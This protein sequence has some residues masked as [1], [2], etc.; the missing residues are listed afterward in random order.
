[1]EIIKFK[2]KSF[3]K[4][5][6]PYDNKNG[7]VKYVCYANVEDLPVE[8]E[9]W[10]TSNPRE[11]N[12]K[13]D[14]AKSIKA[15]LESQ[16]KNFHELNRGI[17]LSVANVSFDNKDNIMTL[18]LEADLHGNIDGGHTLRI[19]LNA[20]KNGQLPYE[21]YVF[22][23]I[24]TGIESPVELAEARN[25]SVQVTLAS[26]E[27]L[28]DTFECIKNALTS[29]AFKD[30]IFYKQNELNTAKNIID[31]REIVAI[32]NMFNQHLYPISDFANITY[33]ISSYTGK[34]SSLKA[35]IRIDKS[36]RENIIS[37]MESIIPDIF[38]L[39]EKIETD[40]AEK[41][42]VAKKIYRAKKYSKYVDI[43]SVAYTTTFGN[44][45]MD[46]VVPKGLIYPL[47]GAFRAL[48]GIDDSGKYY[49]KKDPFHTWEVL[50]PN[51]VKMLLTQS[52]DLADN[53][54]YVGKSQ[55]TWNILFKEL[56]IYSLNNKN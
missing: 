33:P 15:S 38:K 55:N 23:E 29:E 47:I 56:Y 40:F 1:M 22:M 6:N 24:F 30:R 10:M 16:I 31:I 35:F 52:E 26:I 41:G 44:T 12:L 42:K 14:V 11:Q 17:V 49:W 18:G 36:I 25:T 4:M 37:N 51:L 46:Y 19:I 2:V 50:G 20:K 9:N 3:K 7:S 13:T 48:I 54:E 21:K 39:W 45:P 8:L 28:K 34:E 27:E 5:D 53:P 32:L 43:S